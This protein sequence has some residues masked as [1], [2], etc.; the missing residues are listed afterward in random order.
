MYYQ[1]CFFL[2]FSRYFIYKLEKILVKEKGRHF[3]KSELFL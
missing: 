2:I 1:T 3:K